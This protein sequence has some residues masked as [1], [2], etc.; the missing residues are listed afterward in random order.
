M[1]SI[2][3]DFYKSKGI[4]NKYNKKEGCREKDNGR[5]IGDAN[6]DE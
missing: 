4:Y 5:D 6:I 2:L 3:V 1:S